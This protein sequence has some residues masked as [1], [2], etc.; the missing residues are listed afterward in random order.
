MTDIAPALVG[1]LQT[2][3]PGDGIIASAPEALAGALDNVLM[4]PLKVSQALGQAL[5]DYTPLTQ[6]V[7]LSTDGPGYVLAKTSTDP[8]D[9]AW[10]RNPYLTPQDFG[11]PVDG[12]T[13]DAGAIRL[14]IAASLSTGLPMHFPAGNYLLAS[15]SSDPSIIFRMTTA[16]AEYVMTGAGQGL[17]NIRLADGMNATIWRIANSAKLVMKD[18]TFDCNK[19]A[20]GAGSWCENTLTQSTWFENL[21][22]LNPLGNG[23]FLDGDNTGVDIHMCRISGAGSHGISFSGAG[24]GAHTEGFRISDIQTQDCV[25]SGVNLSHAE[26][27][28]VTN[29]TASAPTI[30]HTSGY[31]ALRITNSATNIVA[32]NISAD[33]LS[34]ALFISDSTHVNVHGVNGKNIYT[35]GVF[36]E[37]STAPTTNMHVIVDGVVIVDPG[38]SGVSGDSSAVRM[39]LCSGVTIGK[40]VAVCTSGVMNYAIH[41]SDGLLNN[42]TA[43]PS[44]SGAT[45]ANY[46][47]TSMVPFWNILKL[48]NAG[49]MG[50][51]GT[52]AVAKPTGVAVSAAGIHAALVT[53]GLIAA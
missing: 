30:S 18:M 40:V 9:F 47:F 34:R 2:T 43:E 20:N 39:S 36:I 22:I 1:T 13:D 48:T 33:S 19:A 15:K 44:V 32:S 29:I 37:F 28:V 41:E 6:G 11:A 42:I 46:S 12:T 27:G 16:S 10:V 53:L 7:P 17:T 26:F 50:F 21:E 25:Q 5:G 45:T 14:M 35:Q 31:A 3:V 8:Y 38:R 49:G 23:I 52:T 51:F 24:G 4:T